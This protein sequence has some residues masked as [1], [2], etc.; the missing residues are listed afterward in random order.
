M[1]LRT[2]TANSWW[3]V[4]FLS[5]FLR[6]DRDRFSHVVAL[7]LLTV[8]VISSSAQQS[9]T[10]VPTLVNF[11]DTLADLNGKP[12]TTITGVTF[13]LYKDEQGGA[14]LWM[15]TQNVTP[16]KNGHYTAVLGSTTAQGLP[17]DLFASGE[18]RW[19]AVQ[20]SGEQEQARVLLVAVPYAMK[21]ADAETLGGLPASAFMLAAPSNAAASTTSNSA[22]TDAASSSA[23]PPGSSD[24]TTTGGTAGALAVFTAATNIQNSLVTQTGTT[25][26][27]VAGKLNLPAI[28]TATSSAGSN[29]R[30]QD[31]VASAYNSSTAAAVN[32]AF[33]W[34]AQPV[35]NDTSTPSGSLNLLFGSGSSTPAQT[36]LAIASNGEITFAKGQKFPGTGDGTITGI[37]TASGSG[38]SGGGTSGTLSLSIPAAGVTNTMLKDSSITLNANS[39]GGLTTPGA[40]TLGSTNTIGLKPCSANQILE[41]SG[42]V[43]NCSSAGTG[44][45]TGVTAGSDLTGGGTSGSVTLNLDTTKVP[46]LASANTFTNGQTINTTGYTNGL[47]INT[48]GGSGIFSISTSGVGVSGSSTNSTGVSG[49]T[50]SASGSYGVYG[51]NVASGGIAIYGISSFGG[52]VGV[53]GSGATG[54]YGFS[55]ATTGIGTRGLWNTASSVGAL[56]NQVGVWGDSS[57]G[58]GVHGTSDS[59]VGVDGIS[60]NSAGVSG[61]SSGGSSAGVTG[62]NGNSGYGVYG[63]A[64]GASGQG[65]WGESFGTTSSNGAG[66]DGVHG[67]ANS[68]A[69]SGVAGINTVQNGTGVFG[70]DTQGYGFATD[71]QTTQ[72]R[73]MGGWVKAMVYITISTSTGLP[74]IARCFNSQL[75]GSIASTVP[76]GITASWSG[77]GNNTMIVDFG[78]EV[79]DRFVVLT[80]TTAPYNNYG[81]CLFTDGCPVLESQVLVSEPMDPFVSFYVLV[82]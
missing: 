27:N 74:S 67:V 75:S 31:F 26:I 81:Y 78:F 41:Y 51:Q 20:I 53:Y 60:T 79:D 22:A 1:P 63:Q 71:S 66:P 32:Q 10:V 39:A 21:A 40:M 12:L 29:S 68:T 37:T 34:Q 58:D 30:P 24:V 52:G 4:R 69:G 62:T 73:T 57:T 49:V 18:A 46:L 64:S 55:N 44:T 9:A 13:L 36:G 61:F 19:L 16:D 33:Q 50:A 54:S 48:A 38:L 80:F 56:T 7:A 2:G 59:G 35:G 8:L 45:I 6:G 25:A 5:R 47:N 42:S 43:W 77:Y 23:P 76:C 28:G 15:E 3:A 11:S 70:S 72:A 82:F 14:P 65:V 17:T